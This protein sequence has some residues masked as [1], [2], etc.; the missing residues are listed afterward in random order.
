MAVVNKDIR[1]GLVGVTINYRW[2][3]TAVVERYGDEEE[4]DFDKVLVECARCVGCGVQPI[5]SLCECDG[6]T[7]LDS[8]YKIVEELGQKIEKYIN[9][10]LELEYMKIG[11]AVEEAIDELAQLYRK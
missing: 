2:L 5:L 10:H 7:L 6:S 9:R 8:E 4:Y 11:E 3:M 1:W